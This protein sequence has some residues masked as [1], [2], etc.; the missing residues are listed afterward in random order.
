ME[1]HREKT[2]HWSLSAK[3]Q[4]TASATCL[5]IVPHLLGRY[6][7]RRQRLLTGGRTGQRSQLTPLAYFVWLPRK[8][9]HLAREQSSSFLLAKKERPFERPQPAVPPAAAPAGSAGNRPPGRWGDGTAGSRAC[10]GPPPACRKEGSEPTRSP[11]QSPPSGFRLQTKC[12]FSS[13]SLLAN[14]GF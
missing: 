5:L 14:T 7:N 1:F 13:P 3:I 6:I 10:S 8:G 11:A 12:L 2:F 9:Q 4:V